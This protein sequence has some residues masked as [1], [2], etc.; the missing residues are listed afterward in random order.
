MYQV[1]YS[2]KL[3]SVGESEGT[4]TTKEVEKVGWLWN[5][6]SDVVPIVKVLVSIL[7]S[8]GNGGQFVSLLHEVLVGQEV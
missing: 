3:L 5:I 7:L 4:V 1:L 8:E 6:E 2:L